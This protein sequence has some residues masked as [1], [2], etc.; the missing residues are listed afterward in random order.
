MITHLARRTDVPDV[1]P[2]LTGFRQTFFEALSIGA[3]FQY[4]INPIEFAFAIRKE[5]HTN[6]VAFARMFNSS[7]ASK[8]RSILPIADH[9]SAQN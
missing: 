4:Q 9:R 3:V 7:S 5:T 1:A 6:H 8:L 2:K